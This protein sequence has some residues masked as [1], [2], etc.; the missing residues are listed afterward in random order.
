MQTVSVRRGL[1]CALFVHVAFVWSAS[2]RDCACMHGDAMGI[3]CSTLLCT[4][5]SA[6]PSPSTAAVIDGYLR[7]AAA[8]R[9]DAPRVSAFLDAVIA[10]NGAAIATP[11]QRRSA[12]RE[13]LALLGGTGNAALRAVTA[14][15]TLGRTAAGTED[16]ASDEVRLRLRPCRCSL[17]MDASHP[18]GRPHPRLARRPR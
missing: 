8:H 2:E 4:T 14:L 17:L 3:L 16:L 18:Q 15:K 10:S 7:D 11:E 1:C 6:V 5:M 12:T 13:T 9:S